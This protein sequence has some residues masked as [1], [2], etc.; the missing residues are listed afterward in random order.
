M[1]LARMMFVHEPALLGPARTF[2]SAWGSV[3]GAPAAPRRCDSAGSWKVSLWSASGGQEG[4]GVE[5]PGVR[6]LGQDLEL[7]IGLGEHRERFGVELSV[8]ENIG[9]SSS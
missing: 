6:F 5:Q 4:V 8:V 1:P 7:D 9:I 2:G 3:S